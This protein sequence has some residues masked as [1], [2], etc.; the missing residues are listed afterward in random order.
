[1]CGRIRWWAALMAAKSRLVSD[2]VI[3]SSLR[4]LEPRSTDCNNSQLS[5]LNHQLSRRDVV[6]A[7]A[8]CGRRS[9]HVEQIRQ[10][11]PD[12]DIFNY[13]AA[14]HRAVATGDRLQRRCKNQRS[15]I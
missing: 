7:V 6:A 5:A 11:G 15:E 9:C 14:S 2:F 13:C 3:R 10:S 8:D 1:M 4:A 12:R